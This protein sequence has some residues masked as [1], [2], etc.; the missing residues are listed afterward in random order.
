MSVTPKDKVLS[1]VNVELWSYDH[2]DYRNNS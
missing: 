1:N 2:D